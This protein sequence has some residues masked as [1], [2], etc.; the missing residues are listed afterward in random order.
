MPKQ[1]SSKK[2][3]DGPVAGEGKRL[4]SEFYADGALV[5]AEKLVGK[6]LCRKLE[7]GSILRKRITEAEA[8]IGEE[9]SACHARVGRTA[10]TSV[11]YESGGHVYMFVCYGI[12]NMFNVVT[13][14]S[15]HPEVALIRGIAGYDGPGRVTKAMHMDKS[16]NGID[17]TT[18]KVLWIEDDGFSF[19]I[20]KTKRIGIDYASEP[21]KSIEWRFV[22]C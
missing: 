22:R 11:M 1:K 15:G 13:G 7:D 10:R 19:D 20:K 16:L 3:S 4:N 6:V 14:K 9:D 2:P 21:Y 17:M 5:V 18:S 12:H 8:Y